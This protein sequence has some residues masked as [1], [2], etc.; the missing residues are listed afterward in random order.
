MRELGPDQFLA[1]SFALLMLTAL[2]ALPLTILVTFALMRRFRGLVARSMRAAAG[3]PVLPE[4]DRSPLGRPLGELVIELIEATR[5][6]AGAARAVSLLCTAR[7]HARRLA[8]TYAAAACSLPLLIAVVYLFAGGYVSKFAGIPQLALFLGLIFLAY[9]TPVAL[10][11]TLVLRKQLHWLI[12]AVL[13]LIAAMLVWDTLIEVD[14]VGMWL[15]VSSVP[16]GAVLLLNMR[17]LRAIG[18]IVFACL[19]LILLGIVVGQTYAALYAL[20]RMGPMRFVREDLAQL[21]LLDAGLIYFEEMRS[22]PAAEVVAAIRAVAASP[23]SVVQVENPDAL[24]TEVSIHFFGIM[25]VALIVGGA[26][27]WTFVRWIARSYRSQRASDQML[28]VD[29]LMVVFTSWAFLTLFAQLGWSAAWVLA[30]LPGYKLVL[31]WYSSRPRS[32][33]TPRTLLLLRVFGFNRRTQRLVDSLGQRWRYIGPIRLIGGPDLADTTIEPHEFFEFLNRRLTR[34]FITG[35]DDLER[36]LAASPTQPDPDG[37]FRID[38][39]FCHDDTW[40]LTVAYLARALDAV[41]MDLRGFTAANQGCVFEVEYLVTAVPLHRI[42]LLVD[43]STDIP[44]LERTL[45]GAWSTMPTTRPTPTWAGIHCVSCRRRPAAPRST[46]YWDSFARPSVGIALRTPL[47]RPR[48]RHRG[49]DR[50][51]AG[52]HD[53]NRATRVVLL[54][55]PGVPRP[56]HRRTGSRR[57]RPGARRRKRLGGR[58]DA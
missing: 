25:F 37:L 46:S 2:I 31:A 10:A 15:L 40:R 6:R 36:R 51:Q 34:A 49:A 7:R 58:S 30:S 57:R 16:T 8:L 27:A 45:R 19:L 39:F 12:F 11:P 44:F 56:L 5:Q 1:L 3:A 54:Q 41:L 4:S 42:V 55:R 26:A 48:P 35:R 20:H 21:P 52:L 33:L 13:A 32:I 29:V 18:P 9:A 23:G 22:L 38:D 24:T 17:R 14:S 47:P 28:A 53:G 43:S 50:A